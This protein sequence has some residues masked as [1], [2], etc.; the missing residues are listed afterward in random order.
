MNKG[1]NRI[2]IIAMKANKI[3]YLF[4][5]TYMLCRLTKKTISIYDSKPDM[6]VAHILISTPFIFKFYLFI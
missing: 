4:D 6:H 5:L 1:K 2:K 3:K